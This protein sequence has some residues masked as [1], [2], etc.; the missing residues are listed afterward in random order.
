MS[1]PQAGPAFLCQSARFDGLSKRKKGSSI[2]DAVPTG[3][4]VFVDATV[5]VYHFTGVSPSCR[6]FLERCEAG[7][8]RGVTSMLVIAEVTH[9]L[10]MIEA[11][12]KGLVTGGSVAKKLR[13]RPAAVKRL[14]VHHELTDL[15]PLM[16]IEVDPL[17]LGMFAAAAK[18]REAHGLLTNDSL[19]V[20]CA[21]ARGVSSIASADADFARVSRL[22]LFQ[23]P[24]IA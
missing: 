3:E 20:A 15:I 1:L 21:D 9:R 6:A 14:H 22:K 17:D 2:L 16:G 18:I 10:M 23:P 13:E 8:V 24:D 19:V 11:V 7:Q 5:F 12:A 4:R